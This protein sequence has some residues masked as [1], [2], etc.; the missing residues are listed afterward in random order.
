MKIDYLIKKDNIK[1][2]KYHASLNNIVDKRI[3][4]L[5][6]LDLAMLDY[7]I[8]GIINIDK[9]QIVDQIVKRTDNDVLKHSYNT[10]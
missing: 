7:R 2:S 9:H 5:N 3:W 4:K 1:I 10:F 8:E 6:T